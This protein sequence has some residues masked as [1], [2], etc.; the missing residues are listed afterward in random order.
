M[1][2]FRKLLGIVFLGVVGYLGLYA[3][4]IIYKP[5]VANYDKRYFYV[6]TGSSFNQVVEELEKKGLVKNTDG[7]VKLAEYKKYNINV[8]PGRYRVKNGMSN[9]DLVN[10]LRSGVQEEV[11]ITFNNIRTKEE[12][13]KQITA[14]IEAK[15]M[16]LLQLLNDEKYCS[17]LGFTTTTITTM[18]LPNTYRFY[19]NTNTEQLMERMKTEY[20]N[21]WTEERKKK[22]Q[23][24][25]LTQSQVVILASIVKCETNSTKDAPIIAGVYLNR[26]EKGMP[27]QADPTLIFALGDFTVKRVLNKDKEINSPYNTYK[28]LGLPPGPIFI[29]PPS[30]IDHVLNYQK[31]NYYYFCAKEDL[32]GHSNFSVN[33]N[34]HLRNARKYQNA[35]NQRGIKR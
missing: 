11:N 5:Q 27:L 15:E 1:K 21:F 13:A 10:L 12:L 25:K 4:N 33:Y 26:L 6:A 7:F 24:L 22:A 34:E 19:W 31:H 3:Y 8:K 35:L 20:K 29:T 28:N 14:N 32:S 9:N 16:D 2:K 30:Y 17:K 18:F 23:D